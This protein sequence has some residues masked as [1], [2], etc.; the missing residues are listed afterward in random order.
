M[1]PPESRR[2]RGWSVAG[3]VPGESVLCTLVLTDL[4]DSAA[5]LARL[6]ERR[7]SELIAR[8]DRVTRDLTRSR[9]GREIDRSDG[10][11]LVFPD[12][13]GAARF[14]LAAHAALRRLS[15]EVGHAISARVG[16]HTDVVRFRSNSVEDV[17]LGA[18]PLEL[19]GVAKVRASRLMTLAGGG[20]TL[21]S[22]EVAAALPAVDPAQRWRVTS[23]GLYLFKGFPSELEVFELHRARDATAVVVDSLK[24]IR[25][26]RAPDGTL[27]RASE[28]RD[29]LAEE[30]ANAFF[31]R[32]RELERLSEELER[33][34]RL[35]T[36]TGPGGTGK[37]RLALRH[38]R[39]SCA[40]FPGGVYFVDLSATRN[41][42]EVALCVALTMG[43]HVGRAPPTELVARALSTR[44]ETLLVLDNFE[45]VV[46][47][48]EATVCAWLAS[49]RS[50]RLLV[51][52]REP[53][54]VREERVLPVPPLAV[55]DAVGRSS[56][57]V[58]LFLDRARTA[59]P[60]V[61][62]EPG[63]RSV[64]GQIVAMLDG[65]PLAIE[66]AAARLEVLGIEELRRKLEGSL[67]LLKSD[68]RDAPARHATL[69]ATLEWSYQLLT[70]MERDALVQCSVFRGFTLDAAEAVLDLTA[71]GGGAVLD[72]IQSL[73]E[74][75]LLLV[76]RRPDGSRR[77]RLLVTVAA[78]AREKLCEAPADAARLA[79]A[80]HAAYF[81]KFGD[82]AQVAEFRRVL[83][84]PPLLIERDNL[85]AAL[86]HAKRVGDGET[87]GRVLLALV[88]VLWHHAAL[89]TL[90]DAIQDVLARD[91]LSPRTRLRLRLHQLR[92]V[93]ALLTQLQGVSLEQEVERLAG[94]VGDPLARAQ[95]AVY[96]GRALGEAG[97]LERARR[98]LDVAERELGRAPDPACLA[99]WALS[100]AWIEATYGSI[101][102]SSEWSVLSLEH[103]LQA[104]EPAAEISAR[105]AYADNC[106]FMEP[107]LLDQ[108]LAGFRACI[109]TGERQAS[110]AV[111][112][113]RV[114]LAHALRLGGEVEAALAQASSAISAGRLTGNVRVIAGGLVEW[115]VAAAEL[116]RRGEALTALAEARDLCAQAPSWYAVMVKMG[117][118]EVRVRVGSP[119][120]AD[121]A[122]RS[123][124]AAV[125][126]AGI[127]GELCVRLER[128]R[129]DLASARWPARP[130][131][132]RSELIGGRIEPSRPHLGVAAERGRAAVRR[133]RGPGRAVPRRPRQ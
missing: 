39:E 127:R 105:H 102:R 111:G 21:L 30:P 79:E 74:K 80:R 85:E 104:G 92:L 51:T 71:A 75:S 54:R 43:L 126:S 87:A 112:M 22:G 29:R 118:A 120:E 107:P 47:C 36:L 53:L 110:P 99:G 24:A 46:S 4:V 23:R 90:D 19:D 88:E 86:A 49:S 68:R 61:D 65:I 73:V 58:E 9:G 3:P 38:A 16:I 64:A 7:G 20:Q 128:A 59:N 125:A 42:L 116:G 96:L 91:G 8:V 76:D 67:E 101:A 45:Q 124:E 83:G 31:G 121:E 94:E 44:P 132:H 129:R 33:G 6:G 60:A 113:S 32:A 11:L 56:D 18:K 62:S 1:S 13:L 27:V 82:D 15:R 28:I 52:S 100:W 35:I 55:T 14:A 12:A 130:A 89:S 40:A 117:D 119:R 63:V 78:F 133:R 50:L 69:L 81:A 122:L 123:A 98:H 5:L 72:V 17:A 95:A 57:A 66:L 131:S 2:A 108:S 37:T 48:V 115:A 41:A 34:A 103:A 114:M 84:P 93:N 70:P 106:L 77:F 10:F 97:E 109:A 26:T 25:V